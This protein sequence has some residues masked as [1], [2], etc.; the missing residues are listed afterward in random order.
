MLKSIEPTIVEKRQV[1][2]DMKHEANIAIKALRNEYA[3]KLALFEFQTFTGD[4]EIGDSASKPLRDWSMSTRNKRQ[5]FVLCTIAT[6]HNHFYKTSK[7][8]KL[9]GISRAALDTMIADCEAEGWIHVKRNKQGHRR[10]QATEIAVQTWLEY[11]NWIKETAFD[12]KFHHL[13]ASIVAMREIL[14]SK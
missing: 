11:S 5:F 10:I 1:S 7:L 14:E 4:R 6:M 12:Y 9:L 8:R 3:R 2:S 13:H